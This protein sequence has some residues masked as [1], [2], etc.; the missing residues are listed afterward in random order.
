MG[1]K[2]DLHSDD[3][4]GLQTSVEDILAP[5]GLGKAHESISMSPFL[6]FEMER[7]QQFLSGLFRDK[8]KSV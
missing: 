3:K 7:T 1:N 6:S 8:N 4:N 5:C 2:D